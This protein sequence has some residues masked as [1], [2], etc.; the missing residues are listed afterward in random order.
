M[1]RGGYGVRIFLSHAAEDTH[2][3]EEVTLTLLQEGHEVF[4]D[5]K[6]LLAGV[7]ILT[8]GAIGALFFPGGNSSC[9]I[10]DIRIV[11]NTV[12]NA[13]LFGIAVF[14][15]TGSFDGAPLKVADHKVV[16]AIVTDNTVTGTI[17][18]GMLLNA[19]GS[20]VANIN[21][22]EVTVKKNTVCGS[23]VMDIHAIG[24]SFGIPA[25]LPP[26]QGTGNMV[27]GSI[28]KNAAS[29]VV[30]ENGI[31]GN[32]ATVTQSKNTPCP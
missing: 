14:W 4:F 7:G 21:D 1:S 17:G 5:R 13:A 12:K 3:A 29:T 18:E 23:A 9:N 27:E 15:G 25:L 19:G 30:V 2:I 6:S 8:Y 16:N 26:N 32:S 31:T 10:L 22:V 24:G 11:R 28:T 20:G